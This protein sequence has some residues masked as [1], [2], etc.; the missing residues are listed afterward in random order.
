MEE[1]Q[2]AEVPIYWQ[3]DICESS[4]PCPLFFDGT[5]S[6]KLSGDVRGLPGLLKLENEAPVIL[7][8]NSCHQKLTIQQN[9][10]LGIFSSVIKLEE[11][12]ES[13]VSWTLEEL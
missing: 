13:L 9:R 12:P 1:G 3:Q 4:Q 8:T 10:P 11:E 2:A 5:L 6:N 7:L